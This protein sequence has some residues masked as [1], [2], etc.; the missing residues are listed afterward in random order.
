MAPARRG[1]FRYMLPYSSGGGSNP[2]NTYACS[3]G[4]DSGWLLA[5]ECGHAMGLGHSGPPGVTGVVDP[6]CKPNY[7]SPMNYAFG[8]GSVGFADKTGAPSLNNWA[9]KEW[10]GLANSSP[11]FV[12]VLESKFRYWVD[13]EN[14]HVD[15]NRD[16]VIAPA[17]TTVR[18]YAN[19]TPSSGGCEYTRYNQS[20]VGGAQSNRAPA[21]ARLE[22]RLYVFYAEAGAVKYA[23]STSSWNC[24]VPD[25]TPCGTWGSERS[26]GLNGAGGVDVAKVKTDDSEQLLIVT[27]GQEGR[28]WERRLS[29]RILPSPFPRLDVW[30]TPLLIPGSSPA[31]GEPSLETFNGFVHLVYKGTDGKIRFNR[32][33]PSTGWTG[34][35][36]ALT[37]SGTEIVSAPYASP[38]MV[39]A[40]LPWK[41]GQSQLYGAFPDNAGRLD[42]WWLNSGTGRWEKTDVFESRPGP[43]FGRPSMAWVPYQSAAESPGRLYLLYPSF[44]PSDPQNRPV[45]MMISYVKTSNVGGTMQQTEK[46]GLN[47]YF[48]N[49][50]AY[51]YGIDLLYEPGVDS[52]LRAA[53]SHL[54]MS[55]RVRPK[56]DG[57][58]DF[59][60]TNYNDWEVLRVG[61]CENLVKEAP[62][63]RVTCPT[64][65]W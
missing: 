50:W 40:Y 14:G 48:D 2:A 43:V 36:L 56:A 65:T 5:H 21:L 52:N 12:N 54:D 8:D 3:G 26:A 4:I 34:E 11:A 35:Q 6:N 16:G 33:N 45:R 53:L 7:P 29:V 61:L 58:Q 60:Y 28:L 9:L 15:W 19:F 17:G 20:Q 37:S 1:I 38:A 46:I 59:A 32:L 47:A 24:P 10:N 13:R 63:P 44:N 62:Q 51:A 55:V 42:I 30:T 25:V 49:V 23:V 18:A 22:N 64:K 27:I 31:S 41:P 39:R 57:I